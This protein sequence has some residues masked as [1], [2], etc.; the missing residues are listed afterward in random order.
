M[1]L[2]AGGVGGSI[3]G[4]NVTTRHLMNI[5]RLAYEISPPPAGALAPGEPGPEPS[6]QEVEQAVQQAV[7]EILKSR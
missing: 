4:D 1:T 2:G 7:E 6:P 5:K 3:T